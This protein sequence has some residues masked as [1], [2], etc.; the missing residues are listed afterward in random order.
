MYICIYYIILYYVCT[1]E[2]TIKCSMLRYSISPKLTE[3]FFTYTK[4]AFCQETLTKEN[5]PKQQS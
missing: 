2:N 1:I 4:L 3:T 5:N